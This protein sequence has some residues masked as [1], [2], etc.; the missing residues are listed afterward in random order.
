[1]TAEVA[2][3]EIT[4]ELRTE[5]VGLSHVSIELG[6]LYAED[7][8]RGEQHIVDHF[9]R[10]KPWLAG[11]EAMY[12]AQLGRTPRVST[13]FLV[14]DY[15]APFS[16]PQKV[17]GWL[18]RAAE[19][20]GVPL[21]YIGRES[22]CDVADGVRVAE[23]VLDQLVSEPPP[24]S[25]GLRPPPR[26]TGWLS[27][28]ER[29]PGSG[30]GQSMTYQPWR[31][32]KENA[33]NRHSVFLD[34]ELWDRERDGSRKWACAFLSA[35]WQLARLGL[36]RY[37]G[38]AAMQ[39]T[40]VE[41]LPEVWSDLPAVVKL[42]ERAKPFSAYR[43]FSVLNSRYLPVEH[44]TRAIL[45]QVPI[46]PE[47]LAKLLERASAEGIALSKQTIERTEYTFIAD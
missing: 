21:D 14:D 31:A 7:F 45:G 43:T 44:A 46:D 37:H 30:T 26:E 28:G 34:V 36:L 20:N 1:M 10:V 6:H 16:D 18:Q 2:F 3:R 32:P 17:F 9:R 38:E 23:L 15:F 33:P 22:G 13:C 29:S 11:I 12:R 39:T 24:N 47:V 19:Q 5:Q 27:N 25:T 41:E 42:N 4:A 35:V 40:R 8:A